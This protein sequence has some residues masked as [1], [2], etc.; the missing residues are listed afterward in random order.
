[1]SWGSVSEGWAKDAA[2]ASSRSFSSTN[3]CILPG[4]CTT[5]RENGG[6]VKWA[7]NRQRRLGIRVRTRA[8][9]LLRR[10]LPYRNLYP[11]LIP[12][13]CS[14]ALS[15]EQLPDQEEVC[16]PRTFQRST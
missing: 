2:I 16:P 1:M 6:E 12:I 10:R 4:D 15:P 14:L 3:D 11:N 5:V 9:V 13:I 7:A 8:A